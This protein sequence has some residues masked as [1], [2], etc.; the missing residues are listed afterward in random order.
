MTLKSLWPSSSD[1]DI[2]SLR[3][4]EPGPR[5]PP[6]PAGSEALAAR[7]KVAFA[8]WGRGE[9]RMAEVLL[10]E[11]VDGYK[12]ILGEGHPS[13]LSAM[14][15]LASLL[16]CRGEFVQAETI[17][18]QTLKSRRTFLGDQHPS[19]LATANDLALVLN[20]LG[21]YSE[22]LGKE[23]SKSLTSMMKLA[24]SLS[25][26]EKYAEAEDILRQTLDI[27]RRLRGLDH[28]KTLDCMRDL[29]VVLGYQGKFLDAEELDRMITAKDD[30]DEPERFSSVCYLGEVS[31]HGLA[32]HDPVVRA[33]L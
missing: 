26:D 16:C 17:L 27:Y 12:N 21:R 18:R 23:H 10:V 3:T 14:N 31:C 28:P 25:A 4:M 1:Y 22:S 13:A 24:K 30:G 19:T 5:I 33:E 7:S 8:L 15:S 11:V 6:A 20:R 2:C 29:S 9:Y 32:K